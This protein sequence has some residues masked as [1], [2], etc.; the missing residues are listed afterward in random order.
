MATTNH[1]QQ[2]SFTAA[3]DFIEFDTAVNEE[4][5]DLTSASRDERSQLLSD[6]LTSTTSD[7]QR[8]LEQ[9]H[10]QI[11]RIDGLEQRIDARAVAARRRM[12]SI[13]DEGGSNVRGTRLT[14]ARLHVSHSYTPVVTA[15]GAMAALMQKPPADGSHSVVRKPSPAIW[16]L[17]LEGR[18]L[19]DHL[20]HASAVQYDQKTGYTAPTDDLDRSRG[21]EEE[22]DKQQRALKFTHFFDKVA[23]TFQ[24]V[25]ELLDR[26]K[27]QLPVLKKKS[28][29]RSSSMASGKSN[30]APKQQQLQ[31]DEGDQRTMSAKHQVVWTCSDTDDADMWSFSYVEP[32]SPDKSKWKVHS[33]VASM[34]LYRRQQYTKNIPNLLS[35]Q[36][37]T[38]PGFIT[39]YRICSTEVQ[40]SLFPNHGPYTTDV[41]TGL[42]RK[43]EDFSLDETATFPPAHNEVHIPNTLTM[44][45]I[46]NAFFTYIQ[47]RRLVHHDDVVQCDKLLQDSLGME[48][49]SY[50]QLRQL[51]IQRQIIQPVLDDDPVRVVYILEQ[52]AASVLGRPFAAVHE[53]S[54]S[55][56][57]LLQ[58]DMDITV[59]NLFPYRA[60]ELLRRIKRRELE[61][62]SSRTKARYLLSTGLS[63]SSSSSNT[64][65]AAAATN[66]QA[67][68]VAQ[69]AM[70]AA[71]DEDERV[72]RTQMEHCVTGQV[73]AADLIPVHLA[74]AKAAL[75][76]TEARMAA[77]LDSRMAYLLAELRERVPA[78]ARA[79]QVVEACQELTTTE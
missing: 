40:T 15:A 48:Q 73:V 2:Q 70:T 32:P 51:L 5:E 75:P 61:Y 74:L 72:V 13:L 44:S 57:S 30:P 8:I 34:E 17:H 21:E 18:L 14:H 31:Q 28:S 38:Q 58:I 3:D 10:S 41:L 63:S 33:V 24:T 25:F 22:S 59:P 54:A 45:D 19:V 78:A 62:T 55:D 68:R 42:K 47:D 49:F 20:D 36:Q 79:W 11:Y 16:T 27:Q 46:A 60:R 50:S 29:R 64:A 1:S 23:V 39:R 52:D 56:L 67:R 77:H 4:S 12:A 26:K 43:R 53:E 69:A 71:K 76:F 66:N 9:F 7:L 6:C 37:Q 65:A 35:P